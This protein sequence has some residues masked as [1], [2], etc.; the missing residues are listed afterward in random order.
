MA[1]WTEDPEFDAY[2]TH[3]IDSLVPMIEQ[4]AV[5]VSIVPDGT[6]DVKFAVEL[7]LSIMLDKPI[8]LAVTPGRQVPDHLARV[9]DAIVSF[10]PENP[11]ST[12]EQIEHALRR[13]VHDA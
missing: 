6:A 10:D 2:A 7:G 8:I 9:A 11:G 5:T 4:S 3:V 13:L 12:G 1:D